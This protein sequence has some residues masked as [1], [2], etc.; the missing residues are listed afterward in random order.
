MQTDPY[1]QAFA[2][3]PTDNVELRKGFVSDAIRCGGAGDLK[4]RMEDGKDVVIPAVLA[5]ETVRVACTMVHSTGTTATN[6][7]AFKY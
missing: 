3:T 1:R 6:I 2:V 7:T 5:G 4:V